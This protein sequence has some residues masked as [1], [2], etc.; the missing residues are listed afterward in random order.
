[1]G[2][3]SLVRVCGLQLTSCLFGAAASKQLHRSS[4]SG[5][6][7]TEL[8]LLSARASSSGSSSEAIVSIISIGGTGGGVADA[9]VYASFGSIGALAYGAATR[10][11]WLLLRGM[12]G[13][14]GGLWWRRDAG[15]LD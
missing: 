10:L 1:M 14:H 4:D 5:S 2:L 12:F 7:A 13:M 6:A 15:R 9:S 8:P 3:R 11:R